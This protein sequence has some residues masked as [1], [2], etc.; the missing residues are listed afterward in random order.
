M[1]NF[2]I[3][4]FIFLFF[5]SSCDKNANPDTLQKI[6]TVGDQTI[7]LDNIDQTLR[8]ELYQELYQI[9]VL[10]LTKLQQVINEYI[11]L[12]ESK[13]YGVSVDSLIQSFF[14]CNINTNEVLNFALS[15]NLDTTSFFVN[16]NKQGL[17]IQKTDYYQNLLIEKFKTYKIAA[18]LDSLKKLYDVKINL[19]PPRMPNSKLKDIEFV[20]KGNLDSPVTIFIISD[21][22]CIN[23][24]KIK[25]MCDNLY[26]KY[27]E[28][29]KFGFSVYSM[30]IKSTSVALKAA[31]NQ[32]KFWE[33]YNSISENSR[34][35]NL[36]IIIK[37]AQVNGLEMKKFLK[38]M[39][40]SSIYH[41]IYENSKR[42]NDAG[43]YTTPSIII[44]NKLVGDPSSFLEIENIIEYEL[45]IYNESS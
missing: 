15:Y 14:L 22:D 25:P 34:T 43:F 5:L 10:R 45:S 7:Y 17:N 4:L 38:D 27:K 32:N 30:E 2:F 18:Y 20:Y 26:E 40:D 44:N 12:L 31:S 29:V 33:M 36:D 39:K 3:P 6:G 37:L 9:Y 23:C 16:T 41:T 24:R 35:I 21:P 11:I 1:I 28:K 13:R 42:I 8:D 19:Q